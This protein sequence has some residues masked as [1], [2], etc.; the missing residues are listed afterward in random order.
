MAFGVLALAIVVAVS[1]YAPRVGIATPLVLVAAG[2]ALTAI[3][4]LRHVEIDPEWI[5]AGVLPPLLYATSTRLPV[6]DFRRDLPAISGLSVLLVAITTLSVGWLVSQVLPDVGFAAGMA[7]GAVISPTDAVATSVARSLGV[8]PRLLTVLEGESLLND[9]SALVLLRSAVAAIATSVS[10]IGVVGSFLYAVL[11]AAVV[12]FVVGR[13]AVRIRARLQD[14]VLSTAVSFG[15]PFAAYLPVELLG[16]SGLVAAVAA[17]L[18]VSVGTGKYLRAQDRL[19]DR[20][21]WSTIGLL[22]EGIVFLIMGMQLLGLVQDVRSEH[23]SLWQ[24]GRLALM[25]GLAVLLIRA[26]YVALLLRTGNRRVRRTQKAKDY[27]TTKEAKQRGYER[28]ASSR[29]TAGMAEEKVRSTWRTMWTRRVADF[30]YI[31]ASPWDARDGTML[32]WAGMRGAVTVAAAQTLPADTPQRSLLVL[33]AF[34]VAGGSLL[35]QGGTLGWVV[36]RLGLGDQPIDRT[37]V[38]GVLQE[39]QAAGQARLH[40]PDLR[41]PDGRPYNAEM[42]DRI[43]AR[44]QTS[45]DLRP[46]ADDPEGIDR[47][48]QLLE[49]RLAVLDAQRRRLLQIRRDGTAPSTVLA[50]ILN[51]L[52]ADQISVELRHRDPDISE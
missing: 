18:V 8:S 24:A 11:V 3:P 25:A 52:D 33:I 23:E 31:L 14:E 6:M 44:T 22:L 42:L 41:R 13:L 30:D 37:A 12:G 48:N 21:N 45:T 10:V 34:F 16:A 35:V 36:R 4:A 46:A 1:F 49:L 40:D 47:A 27:W 43:A 39:V 15:V 20:A 38:E 50:E 28:V 29:R 26:A 51:V 2:V 17:G 9:A 5:L 19:A 7:L 32:V